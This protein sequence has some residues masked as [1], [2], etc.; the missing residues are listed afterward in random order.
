MKIFDSKL[1]VERSR[2]YEESLKPLFVFC[3]FFSSGGVALEH[4]LIR[5]KKRLSEIADDV[6]KL[7]DRRI[8]LS[9][10]EYYLSN[11][12]KFVSTKNNYHHEMPWKKSDTGQNSF[13]EL[14]KQINQMGNYYNC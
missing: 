6:A 2:F 4:D 9:S 5:M 7:R 1:K 3:F 10:A 12:F 14:R 8:H 11:K 13:H